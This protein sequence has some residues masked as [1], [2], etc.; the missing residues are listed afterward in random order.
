MIEIPFT[1]DPDTAPGDTAIQYELRG[2][3]RVRL[4]VRAGQR[5][6]GG[7]AISVTNVRRIGSRLIVRCD[8]HAPAPGAIV[9]QVLSAPAQTVSID[10]RAARGIREVVLVDTAG[11]ERAHITA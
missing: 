6:T 11:A 9:A 2:D 10:E 5:R 3:G 7:H 4:T 1:V 8:V